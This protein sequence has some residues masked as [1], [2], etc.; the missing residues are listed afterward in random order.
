MFLQ[1]AF[2]YSKEPYRSSFTNLAAQFSINSSLLL[3]SL[4]IMVMGLISLISII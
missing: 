2:H 3:V 4:L 1:C